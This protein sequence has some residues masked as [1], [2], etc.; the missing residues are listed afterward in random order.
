MSS[1]GIQRN[2]T[3]CSK[4]KKFNSG[5]IRQW[6]HFPHVCCVSSTGFHVHVFLIMTLFSLISCSSQLCEVS[7]QW[8]SCKQ[9]LP[10]ELCILSSTSL[11]NTLFTWSLTFGD[12]L[13]SQ[14]PYSFHFLINGFSGAP[15][16]VQ[17]K[18]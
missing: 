3:L 17:I 6:N 5:L 18:P 7:G 12:F 16:D 2:V 1:V 8:F 4:T 14:F 13:E 9:L 15:Q 10:S 11:T